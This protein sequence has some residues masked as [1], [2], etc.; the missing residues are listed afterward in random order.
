MDQTLHAAIGA[1]E[2]GRAEG[3]PAGVRVAAITQSRWLIEW[4]FAMP[5]PGLA[6]EKP[7][8]ASQAL[9]IGFSLAV[10][11]M[12]GWLVMMIM[13]SHDANTMAADPADLLATAARTLPRVE[14]AAPEPIRLGA[15]TR[16][17]P[18]AP[19]PSGPATPWLFTPYATGAPPPQP[20]AAAAAP[21][22]ASP[23]VATPRVVTPQ[24]VV[25]APAP[26][27]ADPTYTTSSVPAS[28]VDINDRVAIEDTLPQTE[29]P[30]TPEVIPLPPPKPRRMAS[31]PVPRP[32]PHLDSDDAQPSQERTFF[33][34]LVNRQK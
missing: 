24:I 19:V 16:P 18:Q 11:V 6:Y 26:P 2:T 9:V 8:R 10:V 22:A 14:P 17:P 7:S 31:I 27:A 30:D 28:V 29:T 34:F 32:R 3:G 33:D 20:A 25:P 21:Q 12:A 13:F 1:Q 5:R 23:Q 4:S 15:V